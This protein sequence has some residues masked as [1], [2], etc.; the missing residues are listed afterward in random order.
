MKRNVIAL[1]VASISCSSIAAVEGIDQKEL[2]AC[3][4]VLQ[5]QYDQSK[6]ASYVDVEA[7]E[8]SVHLMR[9][10]SLNSELTADKVNRLVT[11]SY[12]S[13][14]DSKKTKQYINDCRKLAESFGYGKNWFSK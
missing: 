1:I 7:L 13:S 5:Y 6:R 2:F 8:M 4:G 9:F 11:N 14:D 3:V 12:V 10:G